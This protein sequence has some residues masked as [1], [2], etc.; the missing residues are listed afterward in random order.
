MVLNDIKL[1]EYEFK[2]MQYYLLMLDINSLGI[3]LRES[4]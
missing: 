1:R 3:W 4:N 2:L